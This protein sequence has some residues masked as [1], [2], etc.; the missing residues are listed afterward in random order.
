MKIIIGLIA[1]VMLFFTIIIFQTSNLNANS[2]SG[3]KKIYHRAVQ[4][5]DEQPQNLK[6]KE[7]LIQVWEEQD[8][9]PSPY[10]N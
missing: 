9:A 5:N 10:S 3:N 6:E 2:P 1:L 7:S 4:L 8:M